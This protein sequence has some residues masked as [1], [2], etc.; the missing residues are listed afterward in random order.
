MKS[1]KYTISNFEYVPS[2]F[3]S[4]FSKFVAAKDSGDPQKFCEIL[5]QI[6]KMLI[7]GERQDSDLF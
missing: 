2:S 6:G 3:R 5:D 7:W 4:L 1:E